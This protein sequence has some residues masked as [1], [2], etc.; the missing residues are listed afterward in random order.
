MTSCQEAARQRALVWLGLGLGLG[1]L[2]AVVSLAF[3]RIWFD[4]DGF[5]MDLA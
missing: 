1:W 2:L 5:L 3:L 4:L